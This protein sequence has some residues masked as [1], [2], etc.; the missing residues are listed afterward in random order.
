MKNLLIYSDSWLQETIEVGEVISFTSPEKELLSYDEGVHYLLTGRNYITSSCVGARTIVAFANKEQKKLFLKENNIKQYKPLPD[1]EHI[2]E[3]DLNTN[4]WFWKSFS[5]SREINLSQMKD[6]EV[7]PFMWAFWLTVN[8]L[9]INENLKIKIW[10]YH[11]FIKND[12]NSYWGRSSFSTYFIHNCS[13]KDPHFGSEI[14]TME[15]IHCI[16]DIHN[17]CISWYKSK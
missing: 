7:R 12:Y 9:L 4:I 11:I 2:H 8:K 16:K 5:K 17:H 1:I 15:A 13:N 6:L 14:N 3:D 10:K